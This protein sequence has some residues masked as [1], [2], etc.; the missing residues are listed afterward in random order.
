VGVQPVEMDKWVKAGVLAQIACVGFSIWA[1]YRG[2]HPVS[3]TKDANSEIRVMNAAW[4]GPIA[5]GSI[6]ALT[7]GLF[8]FGV[9]RKSS[10][11]VIPADLKPVALAAR[12]TF[13]SLS[14]SQK[15]LVRHI[16]HNPNT[17]TT[18][19]LPVL[20]NMGF[21][22]KVAG[23]SLNTVLTTN[24]VTRDTVNTF[25]NPD[26]KEIVWKLIEYDNL[27]TADMVSSVAS[28]TTLA[29][30][31]TA[32]LGCEK[33]VDE[34]R[35]KHSEEISALN[36]KLAGETSAKVFHEGQCRLII[37]EC[38]RDV[39]AIRKEL[40][41]ARNSASR[42]FEQYNAETEKHEATRISERDA[43]TALKK[44][45]GELK[46]LKEIPQLLVAYKPKDS[47]SPERLVF[48]NDGSV[49]IQTITIGPILWSTAYR[50]EINLHF[51]LG[52]M[53]AKGSAECKF[54]VFELVHG[55]QILLDLPSTIREIIDRGC[56]APP[57]VIVSYQ[58]MMGG[59]FRRRFILSMDPWNHIAWN[60]DPVIRSDGASVAL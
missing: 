31:F 23:D 32:Q 50:R 1:A 10:R 46:T 21:P 2:E 54:A 8:V 37:E 19:L 9:R 12:A 14:V 43:I 20:S 42:N 35:L 40:D 30:Q 28:E 58:D 3:A 55:N 47:V 29:V 57:E 51:V 39:T 7:V 24:L 18:S 56:E 36:Y 16:Y 49:T 53:Q 52:P 60:P 27:P 4:Y 6:L 33:L 13:E 41:I 48:I 59:T 26:V 38:D 5:S 34:L 17:A 45:Q 11:I 15:L 25:P 44:A 22:A